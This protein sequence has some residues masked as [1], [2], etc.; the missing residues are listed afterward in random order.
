MSGKIFKELFL[1]LAILTVI[2]SASGLFALMSLTIN[3]KV[4]EIGIRKVMGANFNQIL[5]LINK[6]YL[7]IVFIAWVL[8][9]LLGYM[10]TKEA[11]LS[12]YKYQV[13]IGILPF[14]I[15]LLIILIVTSI[16]MGG[17][18]LSAANSNP[19]DTLRAE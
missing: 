1:F 3:R 6:P 2:L 4:K 5:V 17:K 15:S 11:F 7:I 10:L 18:V 19:S 12:Q 16:T 13:E 14:V 8:G 9:I